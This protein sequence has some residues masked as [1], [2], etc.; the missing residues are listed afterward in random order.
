MKRIS[1]QIASNW[2]SGLTVA[3]VSIP[4]SLSLAIASGATPLMG[5][6]TAIWA[7]LVAAIFAGS[8]FNVIGPAGAL[9]GILAVFAMEH[10][11]EMLPMLAILSGLVILAF[12]FLRW[13]RYLIFIPS[14]VIHGFTLGVGL[15]IG[16]GQINFALGLKDLP[17]HETLVLNLYESILHIGQAQL[18]TFLLFAFLLF[19]LF[20]IA[21]WI[22]RIPGAV[23]AA[24]VGI[25]IG[26]LS[27]IHLLPFT[28]QTV[29]SKY[30][31]FTGWPIQVPAFV[32]PSMELSLWKAVFTVA[33]VA[34]LETL[35]SA[36]IADG[37]TKKRFNQKKEMLA[38]SLANIASG[39]AGGLPATGVL[40]RT[41]LN[42]QSGAK[43]RF[44]SGINAL[45]ILLIALLFF[46]GFQYLPLPVVASILVFVSIRMIEPEHFIKLF[47]FDQSMFWMAILVGALTFGVD[48]MIGILVGSAIS[49]LV[50]VQHLSR[51]QSELTLHKNKKLLARIPV[52]HAHKYAGQSDVTVY[53]FAGELTY[54][55]GKSHEDAMRKIHADTLI[56]SLR[57]LFYIDL[58]GLEALE[59]MVEHQEA[60]GRTVLLTGASEYIKPLLEKASW[61][62]SREKEG[63]V[64]SSTTDALK[65]LGF[66]L[67]I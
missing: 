4:L 32:V 29:L 63:V 7:G 2:K 30:G 21:R 15:T 22:P 53:R 24:A 25:V 1:Q 39:L 16:L 45:F 66:P 27:E 44:S 48:P 17:A 42:I 58:D 65:F 10:G 5:I 8:E 38:L 47:R 37:M 6:I 11:M 41:A 46:R 12:Y 35:L 52:S 26:Y 62:T 64:F 61:F 14:S 13:D 51:G 60:A 33:V 34:I 20:A 31:A 9:S 3:L 54:F 36:K 49:L 67:G 59:N 56:L 18:H 23:V 19:V 28:F 40:A 57:N 43:S 50:F 55:N